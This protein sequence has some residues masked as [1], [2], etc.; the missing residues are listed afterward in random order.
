MAY[1]KLEPLARKHARRITAAEQIDMDSQANVSTK[2]KSFGIFFHRL[3]VEDRILLLLRDKYGLSY[4]EI[5]SVM[6]LPEATLKTRRQ[7]AL[8]A[9][10]EWIWES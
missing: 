4:L 1:E 6:R 3:S 9:L 10:E 5:A 2:L 8:H 7:Q